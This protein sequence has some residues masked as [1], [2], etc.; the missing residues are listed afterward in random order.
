MLNSKDFKMF[1]TLQY[2][3]IIIFATLLTSCSSISSLKFW[4]N[5]EANLDEPKTLEKISNAQNI[6]N[7]WDLSFDG[8]NSLGNFTP[9]FIGN[10]VFFA[11][12]SGN[13]KSIN[14]SSGKI[15]WQKDINFLST[16]VSAGFGILVVADIDG[17]IISLD[18]NNGSVLWTVNVKGL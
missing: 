4:G 11:D 18:Q 12:S 3:L 6:I 5:D 14:S 13:I 9:S 17:N 16:G 10:N 8:E 2:F 7:N 15:N 1:K